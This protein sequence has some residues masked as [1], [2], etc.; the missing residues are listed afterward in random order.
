MKKIF[1]LLAFTVLA[2]FSGTLWELTIIADIPTTDRHAIQ[3]AILEFNPTETFV[4]EFSDEYLKI[5][6]KTAK[7]DEE[8]DVQ[9]KYATML[10]WDML[11]RKITADG[12]FL[13]NEKD[14]CYHSAAGSEGVVMSHSKNLWLTS[15]AFTIDGKPFCYAVPFVVSNGSSQ[16]CTLNSTNLTSLMEVYQKQII[17]DN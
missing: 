9:I 6:L 11:F 5:A 15:K 13:L 4:S 3:L 12:L 17:K 8:K 14:T 7:T 16:T 10:N 1:L 2:V